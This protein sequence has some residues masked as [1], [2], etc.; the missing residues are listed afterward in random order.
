MFFVDYAG[1][2]AELFVE[3]FLTH[4]YMLLSSASTGLW[5]L[6]MMRRCVWSVFLKGM[7]ECVI[8]FQ[9]LNF[10]FFLCYFRVKGSY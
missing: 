4:P 2:C 10:N 1:Q 9:I 8:G 6:N 5:D 7:R 3:G